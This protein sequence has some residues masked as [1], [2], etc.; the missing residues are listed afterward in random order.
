MD[1]LQ[2]LKIELYR[3]SR[4]DVNTDHPKGINCFGSLLEE[5]L[6]QPETEELI[7]SSQVFVLEKLRDDLVETLKSTVENSGDS[8]IDNYKVR[9][10]NVLFV[11][12]STI[13]RLTQQRER[14]GNLGTE[15]Q[16]EETQ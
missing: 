2:E 4:S 14:I 13:D 3:A 8:N 12:N 16:R 1:K 6:T 11:M 7:L 10:G 5:Y 9:A 15:S